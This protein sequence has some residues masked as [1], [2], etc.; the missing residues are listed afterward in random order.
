MINKAKSKTVSVR[1]LHDEWVKD[2]AYAREYAALADEFALADIFIKARAK[3]GLTQEQIAQAMGTKQ[4]YVA[5]L[6]SG[7]TMPSVRTLQRFAAAT[8]TKLRVQFEAA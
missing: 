7:R 2:P 4:S 3:S 6:E 8:G 5:R 1:D